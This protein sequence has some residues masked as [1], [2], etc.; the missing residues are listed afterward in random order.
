MFFGILRKRG[1]A[2]CPRTRKMTVLAQD[3]SVSDR[4]GGVLKLTL[5]VPLERVA[6]GPKG[7][8]VHV[9]DY[10]VSTNTLYKPSN[11]DGNS[12]E[13]VTDRERFESDRNFHAQ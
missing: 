1:T 3:P 8:R 12:Y 7:S 5:D 6:P 11:L 2:P 4:K 9:I 10:D 13:K